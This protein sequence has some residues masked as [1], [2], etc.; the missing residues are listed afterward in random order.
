MPPP[1]IGF[2]T[3]T[4]GWSQQLRVVHQLTDPG[5]RQ[6]TRDGGFAGFQRVGRLAG[7]R[8]AKKLVFRSDRRRSNRPRARWDSRELGL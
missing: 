1:K 6:E 4:R 5:G 8:S 3:G 7:S 2:D